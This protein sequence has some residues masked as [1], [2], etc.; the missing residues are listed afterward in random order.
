M[1]T[2]KK[3]AIIAILSTLIHVTWQFVVLGSSFGPAWAAQCDNLKKYDCL[4]LS[5]VGYYQ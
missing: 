5:L 1:E 3:Y 2:L 4:S